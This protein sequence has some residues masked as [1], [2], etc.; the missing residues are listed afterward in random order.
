MTANYDKINDYIKEFLR[1]N[2]YQS[3]LECLEAEERMIK[4]TSKSGTAVKTVN[5][6]ASTHPRPLRTAATCPR[7]TNYSKVRVLQTL[8]SKGLKTT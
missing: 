6:S 2:G 4:V 7:C 1:F 8:E 3:T 5:V